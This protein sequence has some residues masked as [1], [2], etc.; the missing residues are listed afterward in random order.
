MFLTAINLSNIDLLYSFLSNPSE[1]SDHFRYFRTRDP[2]NI[3]AQH[4]YTIVGI[5]E[6]TRQVIAYG[7]IDYEEKYWLGICVL[8]SHCGKGYGKQIMDDLLLYADARDMPLSLS[9]DIDNVPAINLY[10]K[11]KFIEKRRTDTV[12]YM[13]RHI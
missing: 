6:E 7:H 5:D 13:G 3:L 12:I 11:Y 10:K 1:L 4:V 8:N 2:K 9:V